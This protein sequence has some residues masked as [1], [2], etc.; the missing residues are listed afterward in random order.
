M[1]VICQEVNFLAISVNP[2]HLSFFNGKKVG[3]KTRL[4]NGLVI[5]QY[6]FIHSAKLQASSHICQSFTDCV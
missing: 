6:L 5:L 2:S 1:Y 4:T 3:K